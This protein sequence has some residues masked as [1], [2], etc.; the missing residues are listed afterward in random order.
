M[1]RFT[2]YELLWL[3]LFAAIYATVIEWVG[4]RIQKRQ[5]RK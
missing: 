3:F 1:I 2:W 5:N 4:K